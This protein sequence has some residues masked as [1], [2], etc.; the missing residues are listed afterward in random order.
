MSALLILL[1]ICSVSATETV[2]S[3]LSTGARRLRSNWRQSHY[4]PSVVLREISAA[5]IFLTCDG[6]VCFTAGARCLL[7]WTNI[8]LC[9]RSE[10]QVTVSW[11]GVT[12][13][14]PFEAN[15]EGFFSENEGVLCALCAWNR[16]CCLAQKKKKPS[17]NGVWWCGTGTRVS[18][19]FFA[20][21][22]NST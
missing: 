1:M 17:R 7:F 11:W 10:N 19:R 21:H 4:F 3:R 22:G 15:S 6:T 12:A 14:I 9:R 18:V 2:L 8:S 20:C 16:S 5:S 13:K